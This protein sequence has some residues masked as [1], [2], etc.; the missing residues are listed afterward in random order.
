MTIIVETGLL[1]TLALLVSVLLFVLE[2]FKSK[3]YLSIV[4][5]FIIVFFGLF[6]NSLEVQLIAFMYFLFVG[7]EQQ[8][9]E[10]TSIKS[11]RKR[12]LK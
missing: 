5:T 4:A 3:R 9:K 12:N 1:G 11:S 7:L 2:Q 10:V 6:I 8:D